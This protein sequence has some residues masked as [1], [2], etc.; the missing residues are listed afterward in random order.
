VS[1]HGKEIAEAMA[2]KIGPVVPLPPSDPKSALAAFTVPGQADGVSTLIDADLKEAG[3]HDMTAKY[4]SRLVKQERCD[5]LRPTVIFAE[6]PDKAITKKEFMFPFCTVVECPQDK[7][8]EKIGPTLVCSA[9]TEDKK[10]Q[11]ALMDAVHID[12]LNIG[13]MKTIALNWLQPH[14]GSIV[15]FLFRARAFQHDGMLQ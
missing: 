2:A 6:S 4:G 11:K 15:D 3:V 10:F 1:R 14:E 8:I 7:M 5:Y 12:R 9:V 13:A